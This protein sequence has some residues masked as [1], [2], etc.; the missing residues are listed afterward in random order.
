[1]IKNRG[2]DLRSGYF[3]EGLAVMIG[4]TVNAFPYTTYSQN[5]GLVSN[6]W[7]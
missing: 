2:K 4:S 7:G 1:M 3:A 5:V 6:F